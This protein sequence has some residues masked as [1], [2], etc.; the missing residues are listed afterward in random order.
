MNVLWTQTEKHPIAGTITWESMQCTHAVLVRSSFWGFL[1]YHKGIYSEKRFPGSHTARRLHNR[2]NDLQFLTCILK[3][4][5]LHCTTLYIVF[6]L[7][8]WSIKS[9]E[10]K[11]IDLKFSLLILKRVLQKNNCASEWEIPDGKNSFDTAH[12]SH[13]V[14]INI[15]IN[16]N[17]HIPSV[18][19]ET[20]E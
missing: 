17:L 9:F 14:Q 4:I 13:F 6:R 18:V 10:S 8:F 5:V 11:K 16:K 7:A 1:L 3:Y 15:E 20:L 2:V 12:W 19:N